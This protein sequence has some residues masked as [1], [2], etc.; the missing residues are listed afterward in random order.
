MRP[1][2]RPI[3]F[4]NLRDFGHS[5]TTLKLQL[6]QFQRNSVRFRVNFYFPVMKV[7]DEAF[8]PKPVRGSKRE[9]SISDSLHPA[10]N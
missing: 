9:I 5:G 4:N 7:A 10:A 1:R 6:E 3:T 8:Y 2:D